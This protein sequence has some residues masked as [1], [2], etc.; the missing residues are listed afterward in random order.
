MAVPSSRELYGQ[1]AEAAL[2]K[3]SGDS[4]KLWDLDTAQS[5]LTMPSSL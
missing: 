4:R 2:S 5:P 1:V 3:L